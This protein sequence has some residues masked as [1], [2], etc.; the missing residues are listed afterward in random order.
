M[1]FAAQLMKRVLEIPCHLRS[2]FEQLPVFI[3][4]IAAQDAAATIGHHGTCITPLRAR[5]RPQHLLNCR[6]AVLGIQRCRYIG[7]KL[8]RSFMLRLLVQL[9]LLY[10]QSAASAQMG[11]SDAPLA[12][13]GRQTRFVTTRRAPERGAHT[14]AAP[15][16]RHI[17]HN[18]HRASPRRS[19]QCMDFQ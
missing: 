17:S 14:F 15:T 8:A 1:L 19:M 10:R 6:F 2:A 13:V 4:L 18:R 11:G 7:W 5:Q 3:Q 12:P 16:S 9:V